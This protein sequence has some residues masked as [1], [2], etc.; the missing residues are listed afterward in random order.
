MAKDS[1]ACRQLHT[2]PK[3]KPKGRKLTH[4][5][6]VKK[7]DLW[8]SK[9]VR[10]EAADR[11]GN[12]RCFTCGKQDHVSNLQAGHFAS[13]RFWATR[14]D[15]DNVRTQCVSCNIYRAGEQWL[16]GCALESEEPGRA[17]QVMRRAQQHRAFKVEELVELASRYKAAALLHASVKRVVHPTRGRDAGADLEE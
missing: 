12:A 5:Q 8:F 13:R 15:Q 2:K 10:Y 9:L 1:K 11:H 3:A 7:V 16:F 4:A 6:A 17:H 14:W